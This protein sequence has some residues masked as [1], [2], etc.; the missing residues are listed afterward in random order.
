M[1]ERTACMAAYTCSSDINTQSHTDTR[2]AGDVDIQ[3]LHTDRATE[4]KPLDL[5]R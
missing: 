4:S 3:Q 1:R 2:R 5:Q